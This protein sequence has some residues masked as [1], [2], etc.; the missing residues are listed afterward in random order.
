MITTNFPKAPVLFSLLLRH[1]HT[2]VSIQSSTSMNLLSNQLYCS[3]M[4]GSKAP[5]ERKLDEHASA[6]ICLHTAADSFRAQGLEVL[7]ETYS[8]FSATLKQETPNYA[9][10]NSREKKCQFMYS[11]EKKAAASN[12]QHSLSAS[13]AKRCTDIL[14][15]KGHLHF[16]PPFSFLILQW[17]TSMTTVLSCRSSC[18]WQQFTFLL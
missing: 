14:N 11:R 9:R 17:T 2:Q 3:F 7:L 18:I 10:K 1:W 13:S 12:S 15:W 5:R 4:W 6:L 8:C 16:F